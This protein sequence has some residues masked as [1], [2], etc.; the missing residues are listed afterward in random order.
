[1]TRFNVECPAPG[2]C[3]R[4]E[5][6]RRACESGKSCDAFLAMMKRLLPEY[7][8]QRSFDG[9]HH[10]V[11][12]IWLCLDVKG[13]VLVHDGFGEALSS[14]SKL[15]TRP[16]LELFARPAL[17]N[18][19][20]GE[21][22]ETYRELSDKAERRLVVGDGGTDA[23]G[24][25]IEGGNIPGMTARA[26]STSPPRDGETMDAAMA[27]DGKAFTAWCA[28]P[29]KSTGEWLELS[30]RPAAWRKGKPFC[31]FAVIPGYAR[32]QATYLAHKRPTLVRIASCVHPGAGFETGLKTSA[33]D[34]F[35]QALVKVDVPEDAL[36]GEGGCVRFTLLDISQGG[37]EPPCVSEVVPEYDC[38]W[39]W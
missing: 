30:L 18:T 23:P 31:G 19:L 35:N 26:S 3:Q 7:D 10:I 29:G 37:T 25:Y 15:D 16:A 28:G 32:T 9:K 36:A 39:A 2:E 33:P 12:A 4:L 13:Y 5:R 6:E 8:C 24:P 11:P 14:L 34:D 38:A 22:A 27:V 17:R 21:H 20:D 1:M